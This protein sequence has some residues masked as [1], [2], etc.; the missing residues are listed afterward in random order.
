MIISA[1]KIPKIAVVMAVYNGAEW[2]SQQIESI[3][4]QQDVNLTLFISIDPSTDQ[5]EALCLS[6]VEKYQNIQLLAPAGTY[7]GAAKN[8]FRLIRDVD[9]SGFDYVSFADQ[10]D[11][12]F[13]NKLA[14]AVAKLKATNSEGYSSNVI[15]FWPNGQQLL[16]EKAQPPREW[17]YFFEAAG[18]GCTYV[19]TVKLVTQLKKIIVSNW[20]EVN[21]LALHDWF[22]YAFARANGYK[23]WIDSEPFM[24]YRQHERNQVGVNKGFKAFVFRV[25]KVLGDSGFNQSALIAKLVCKKESS[26]VHEYLNLKR[27]GFV[28]L[29][30]NFT[31]CR[32]KPTERALFLFACL[33]MA[34]F[35]NKKANR[36]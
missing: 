22:T 29:A 33:Y 20:Q 9:F 32:R 7:G 1:P 16:I 2:I 18:P 10:D 19:M 8:F 14:H 24:L 23:W 25:K 28:R 34:I 21:Q 36:A 26:F 5:S 15:A 4:N 12:W 27:S 3:L 35:N 31:K 6:F 13:S 30:F 17:D 11:I